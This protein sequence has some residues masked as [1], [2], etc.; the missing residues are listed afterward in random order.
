MRGKF[1]K[2]LR[3]VHL[4]LFCG[5]DVLFVDC[6][7]MLRSLVACSY[8][9]FSIKVNRS[10]LR[11]RGSPF[12]FLASRESVFWVGMEKQNIHHNINVCVLRVTNSK[13]YSRGTAGIAD[14][15]D[16]PAFRLWVHLLFLSMSAHQASLFICYVHDLAMEKC[17]ACWLFNNAMVICYYRLHKETTRS[18]GLAINDRMKI[19]YMFLVTKEVKQT[20]NKREPFC[21]K[22]RHTPGGRARL[23]FRY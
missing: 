8:S 6:L 23:E 15:F 13:D 19:S 11:R 5:D 21:F 17:P 16:F 3:M 4:I 20:V 22:A 12:F 14:L 9:F 7:T 2:V 10:W 1:L 18:L